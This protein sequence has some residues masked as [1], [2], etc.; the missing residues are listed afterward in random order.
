MMTPPLTPSP[1]KPSTSATASSTSGSSSSAPVGSRIP[2]T[3]A[4]TVPVQRKLTSTELMTLLEDKSLEQLKAENDRQRKIILELSLQ[5]QSKTEK[6]KVSQQ[7]VLTAETPFLDLS[8]FRNTINLASEEFQKSGGDFKAFNSIIANRPEFN[9]V[10]AYHQAQESVLSAKLTSLAGNVNDMKLEMIS[11]TSEIAKVQTEMKV[12]L[13]EARNKFQ[14][15]FQ[16]FKERRA[17]DK[18]K[19][20]RQSQNRETPAS[21]ST[22]NGLL[23]DLLGFNDTV[24]SPVPSNLD[25]PS[26]SKRYQ[27]RAGTGTSET[28]TGSSTSRRNLFK[29][30][31]GVRAYL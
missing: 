27:T 11:K 14:V 7:T 26:S 4:T 2:S 15:A 1:M 28:A 13:Q 22:D 16:K 9:P 23:E 20:E 12:S 31:I 10:Q 24:M 8:P 25:G 6:E 21:A 29:Y 5:R 17:A 3:S 18:D 19:E 30:R